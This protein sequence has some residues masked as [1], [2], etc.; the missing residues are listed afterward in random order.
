MIVFRYYPESAKATII[1]ILLTLFIGIPYFM[2]T[3]WVLDKEQYIVMGILIVIGIIIWFL[4]TRFCDKIA[5]DDIQQKR[6]KKAE[7]RDRMN[8]KIDAQSYS[9]FDASLAYGRFENPARVTIRRKNNVWGFLIKVKYSLTSVESEEK[10][11]IKV[12]NNDEVQC[13]V[14]YAD[15][16][17]ST[18]KCIEPYRLHVSQGEYVTLVYAGENLKE[19]IREC[20][21]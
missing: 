15:N 11:S 2:L 18:N 8:R 21:Y 19:V 4:V 1:K 17:V 10:V 14:Y 5:I 9:E 6:Q 13:E 7:E 16:I 3:A 20:K 12:K